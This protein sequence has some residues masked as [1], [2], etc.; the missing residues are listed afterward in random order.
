[1]NHKIVSLLSHILSR[2]VY[3]LKHFEKRISK[4]NQIKPLIRFGAEVQSDEYYTKYHSTSSILKFHSKQVMIANAKYVLLLYI[5][6]C[7]N[8]K[9]TTTNK[10]GFI[11]N[12]VCKI[13]TMFPAILPRIY[14]IN[15]GYYW[16]CEIVFH[17]FHLKF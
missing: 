11:S 17:H 5:K 8:S 3:L 16:K 2:Y 4:S 15:R 6:N 12:H 9:N 7:Q 1:M 14:T 13:L 10:I